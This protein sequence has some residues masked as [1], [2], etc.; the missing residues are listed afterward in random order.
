MTLGDAVARA[1]SAI[2]KER[3]VDTKTYAARL[4]Y[5]Q[6]TVYRQLSGATRISTD[7]LEH[8]AAGLG[9]DVADLLARATALRS[10]LGALSPQE[11]EARELMGEDAWA[12]IQA[13]RET[14]GSHEPQEQREA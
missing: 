7:D 8:L 6:S 13:T 10:E 5:A 3:R 9:M 4:P 11:A 12:E 14:H 1:V 2:L